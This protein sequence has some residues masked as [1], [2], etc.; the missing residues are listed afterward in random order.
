MAGKILL[1][2]KL[3]GSYISSKS[4][5]SKLSLWLDVPDI[6]VSFRFYEGT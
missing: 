5:S 6:N 3:F 4:E 2:A 1:F